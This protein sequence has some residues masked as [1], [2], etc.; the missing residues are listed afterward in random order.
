MAHENESPIEVTCTVPDKPESGYYDIEGN[1]HGDL[2]DSEGHF[3]AR[4]ELM[5][6][7]EPVMLLSIG[8]PNRSVRVW[9]FSSGPFRGEF[10]GIFRN[11]SDIGVLPVAGCF[12]EWDPN[13]GVP[14]IGDA[15][16]YLQSVQC[17]QNTARI[18]GYQSHSSLW[19]AVGL[20]I[21]AHTHVTPGP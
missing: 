10:T 1:K 5:S 19:G 14:V 15:K 7:D 12:T 20:V 9:I 4:P 21:P 11:F 3:V 18:I 13:R 16:F 2:F 8:I 17:A 6:T